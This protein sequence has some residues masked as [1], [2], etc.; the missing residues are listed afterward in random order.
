MGFDML[1]NT[2]SGMG[3]ELVFENTGGTILEGG[4][5]IKLPVTKYV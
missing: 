2:S 5:I 4:Y 1:S 3:W